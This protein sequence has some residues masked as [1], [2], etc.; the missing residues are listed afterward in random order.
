MRARN[1]TKLNSRLAE[2]RA[3][4]VSECAESP[5]VVLTHFVRAVELSF[6]CR[7]SVVEPREKSQ[8]E[9]NNGF[10]RCCARMK[11]QMCA[12]ENEDVPGAAQHLSE[13][14]RAGGD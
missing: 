10:R 12:D 3:T 11:C 4:L 14:A 13:P 2:A 6:S 8:F 5:H 9:Y 1:R 7:P